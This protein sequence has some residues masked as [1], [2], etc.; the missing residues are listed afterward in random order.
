MTESFLRILRVSSKTSKTSL[1]TIMFVSCRLLILRSSLRV[2]LRK[3]IR[4]RRRIIHAWNIS[5]SPIQFLC[6]DIYS[7]IC[8]ILDHY[9]HCDYYFNNKRKPKDDQSSCL[10]VD[11]N[12]NELRMFSFRLIS[13]RLLSLSLPSSSFVIRSRCFWTW[14]SPFSIVPFIKAV[15]AFVSF[16]F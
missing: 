7:N 14:S 3:A 13:S 10:V 4:K 6:V 1:S 16:C 5:H 11:S 9:I 2:D 8:A 12:R 15:Y